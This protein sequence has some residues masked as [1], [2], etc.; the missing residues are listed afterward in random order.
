MIRKKLVKTFHKGNVLWIKNMCPF[1][2]FCPYKNDEECELCYESIMKRK[3]R[4]KGIISE[5]KS[6]ILSC[7]LNPSSPQH[8]L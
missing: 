5:Q 4:N 3:N 6:L 2:Y 8:L 1:E 7:V